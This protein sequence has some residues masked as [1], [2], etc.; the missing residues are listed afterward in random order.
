MSNI[1]AAV[2]VA[3]LEKLEEHL[4][5]KRELGRHY[6]ELLKD[7]ED[8]QL[9]AAHT[10]YADNIYWVFG[11][12]LN[13]KRGIK[14]EEMIRMLAKE[15]IGCR[16]FFWPMHR[17]PVF[18]NMG[19][20]NGEKYPVAERISEYGFYVPSGLTVNASQRIYI[21]DTLKR[22]LSL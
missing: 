22:L 1:Q 3:Q 6:Q 9:P 12:V 14:A 18:I 21:A 8:I 4:E 19:L 15:N 7:T 20:F 13:E 16:P 17:Q 10:S 11:I 2:G 5:L